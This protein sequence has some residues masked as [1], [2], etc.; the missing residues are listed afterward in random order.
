MGHNYTNPAY[1]FDAH[2]FPVYFHSI[3]AQHIGMILTGSHMEGDP[4][5]HWQEPEYDQDLYMD[6]NDNY[7]AVESTNYGYIKVYKLTYDEL[8]EIVV[9]GIIF[10]SFLPYMGVDLEEVDIDELP[11]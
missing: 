11:F 5:D 10:Q 9:D 7:Y 8:H 2:F 6:C 3:N 4:E 1:L